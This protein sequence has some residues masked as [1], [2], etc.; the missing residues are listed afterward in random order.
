MTPEQTSRLSRR[1]I[2]LPADKRR[3]FLEQ[4][5][6]SGLDLS[7][8][9]I[10]PDIAPAGRSAASHAQRR[11]WFLWKLEPDSAAYHI[12]GAA[13]LRGQ[14]DVTALAQAFDRLLARHEGLRTTFVQDDDRVLQQVAAVASLSIA[15]SD[16]GDLDAQAREAAIE[17]LSI[18]EASAPFDLEHGPLLRVHL[19]RLAPDDHL[20][21]LTIHHIVF[22]G[23][24]MP[25]LL[26]ELIGLYDALSLGRAPQPK[27]SGVRYADYAAWQNAWL[28]AGEGE[29]QL[30]YWSDKLG[31]SEQELALPADRP[32]PDQPSH[33]GAAIAFSLDAATTARLKAL[34]VASRTTIYTV[35]AAAFALFLY[36]LTGRP[37][38]HIGMPAAGR[39]R[40]ELQR[41]IGLFVNMQVLR[42]P[43][44]PDFS[45]RRCVAE[46]HET[47]M[48]AQAHQDLPFD[49]LV[50][51][52]RAERTVTH[53]P[54][55]QVSY[56]HEPALSGR[57]STGALDWQFVEPDSRACRFDL[58][59]TTTEGVDGALHGS[60]R[61]A[62]DLFDA[63]TIEAW[64][65]A[66]RDL[67]TLVADAPDRSV[68][69]IDLLSTSERSRLLGLA[70][71]PDARGFSET[72]LAQIEAR[73]KQA[74]SAAAVILGD[75]VVSYGELNARANR[76]ARRLRAHGIGPDRLVGLALER[77]AEMIVAL[78]AV[79]KAGGAYLPL[80]PDYPVDRLGHMLRDSG[81]TLVLMHG[82]LADRLAPVLAEA[83][84][85][86]WSIDDEPSS[87]GIDNRNL[88]LPI[89][90]E[91]LAYVIYTSGSTGLPKGVAVAHGPLAMH[92][93][94]I[95][96]LYGMTASDRELQF[97]SINFDIAHERWLVPLT[98]GGAL[99]LTRGRDLPIDDLIAEVE[100]R[101]V[102]VLFLPPA[103][104]NQ[105]SGTLQRRGHQ[106]KL[107]ACIVG[108]EA[109]SDSGIAALRAVTDIDLLVNAYGPTETVIAPMA[110]PVDDAML[111]PGAYA[112]I[113]RPVGARSAY[114]LDNDL[115]L[116]PA[117]VTGE[118][119]IGGEGLARGYWGRAGLTAERF[120][121]D[122]FGNPGERL[123]RTGDLARWRADGLVEYVGRSDHQVKIRGFRI[124]LGEIEARLLLQAGVRAA[125]VVARDTGT[126][127]QLVGYVSGDAGLDGAQLRAT[128][129]ALLPDYMVPARI[130]VLDQLPLT[131]NGKVDRKALPEPEAIAAATDHVAPRNPVEAKLAAIWAE[132]LGQQAVSV[133]D[134]FFE[135][136]GDSIVSLQMVSRARQVGL[137]IEPRDVFRHQTLEA[138]A[139]IARTDESVH[140]GPVA[141]Q[142]PVE[143]SHPLLPIQLRFFG[144]DAG[145]RHHWNQAVLLEPRTRLDWAMLGRALEAVVDHHDALRLRFTETNGA[146]SAEY[147]AAPAVSELL[148]LRERITD[149]TEVTAVASLAQASLSLSGP[150]L[151]AVG[152]DLVDGSQRLLVVI[153]HLVIDGVSWRVL[154]EDVAAA[155]GQLASGATA[156][157]LPPKSQSFASW[158]ARL[159]TFAT[160]EELAAELPYW[161]ERRSNIQLSCDGDHDGVDR[162]ADADE[163][164]LVI[165]AALTSRLLK[166]TPSAYR[167]QVNDLLLAA[168]ARS[169]RQ[170]A[171][172]DELPIELEGHGREDVF[173]GAEIARTVGWFTTAFPVKLSG[174]ALDD[175]ELI[176]TVKEELRSIPGRGLGY[177]VLRYLGSDEQRAA[178]AAIDDPRIV[179]N[180]LGQLDAGVGEGS[181]F[182]MARE[183]AGPM[184]SASAPLGRWL[185]INGQVR[186]GQLRLSF[187]YGR[188]RYRRA[189][190]ERLAEAYAT[191]LRQLVDHCTGGVA[192][193]TPSDVAL[194]EL[195]QSELDALQLD[196]RNVEDIYP[197]SPMQQG[198]L[199]H[200]L[201]DA[202]SGVYVNQVA[203]E[204][205]GLDPA[206][207]R[208][209]WQAVSA[210]HAVLRT[211]FV[212]QGLS[213]AAQQV[214]YRQV[215]VPFA[216]EDWRE[217]A[218]GL[219]RA[220]LDATLANASQ[221]ERALGFD[222]S[223]PPMQR[224]RM[225]RLT[226]DSHWLIWTHHHILLDG[227][228]SARLIAEVLQHEGGGALPA[229][230]GHYRDY[231]GWLRQRDPDASA[232]FWRHSLARLD[233]PSFLAD[234]LGAPAGDQNTGHGSLPLSL[235]AE[236]TDRLQSFARRERV[237]LNTLVQGA[238][239]Q[240][241]RRYTGQNTISF[242]ATVSG[243]PADLAGSEEMIGLFIN[244]LP[245]VDDANP[246]TR[247]GDWLR[248]L[249]EQNLAL[250]EHGWTP[251]YEI[252][253]LA[254]R[255]GRPLF[256]SILV[257]EN[258]PVDQALR[259]KSQRVSVGDSKIVETS[260]YPLFVM[261]ALGDRLR[262]VFNYQLQHFDKTQIERLQSALIRLLDQLSRDAE[263]PLGVIA[264]QDSSD[265]TLLSAANAT[266]EF[267]PHA[268]LVAQIE[269]QAALHLDAVALV[270]GDDRIS[271]GELNARAN[272]LARRLQAHGIGPDR[273]VGLALGRNPSMMVA[274]L[275]VLKAG[276][277][278][279]PLDPDYPAERLA[280]M[281]R[282]SGATL[283]LTQRSLADLMAP[284]LAGAEVEAWML[285]EQ[286]SSEIDSGNLSLPIHPESLAYVIYT[287]GSTGL[288]KGVMVRHDAV[289]NFVATM[290]GQPGIDARD[291]VLG[292]TSLSFD[293]AVLELWLPL[294]VGARIVLVDRATAHDPARLK[295]I[296]ADEA[297]TVIQATPSTWRMLTDHE[298]TSLPST[299]RV[300][301]GGEALAPD[302]AR[303][304][305]AQAGEVWNVY[306]PTETTVWS[307]RHLLDPRDDR[308]RLGGPIGNTTLHI[309]DGDLNAAP[310]G[311]AGELYIGGEGLARGYWRRG[312]LTA[313]RFI[314]DPFATKPGERLYRTGDL[315]RWCADGVMEYVGR[316]DHQVKIRGFRI[317]LGEIETR[318]RAQP[319]VRDAVVIARE[320]GAGRQLVGY[321]VGED[322]LDPTSLR[323]AL[324]AQL[325][326]YMV[327]SR[328]VI[329]DR[330]PLTPNGKVDR[331]ALPAPD[332]LSAATERVAPRNP[333][334]VKLAAIWAD[335]LKQPDVGVTDNF[336]E[337]GGDSLVAVQVVDRIK[338]EFGCELPLRRLFEMTSVETMAAELIVLQ[339]DSLIEQ[340][341]GDIAAMFD[342]L[343]EVEFSDD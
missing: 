16:L 212:W 155:Y 137:I 96:R 214:V 31:G 323:A 153:H 321:V 211:G 105:L 208:V 23:W 33:R 146:W 255:P 271:Y 223:H 112:P 165:D 67:L 57:R 103:Y 143:G 65:E 236:L 161:Q 87:E 291:G 157:A 270:F 113:G 295:A 266:T 116:V 267:R 18:A 135:L 93:A 47:V 124:E 141:E 282:D 192:G 222:L 99:V 184:R 115:N 185:S 217:R 247:V 166:D 257:F 75:D 253:R 15:E 233:E 183:S 63:S 263:Q 219:D 318:L 297:V 22:D 121:P 248:G 34:G 337:L 19:I 326:D 181:P 198:L 191:A 324:A 11:M 245:V 227:W 40:S 138:L 261:V 44:M 320:A 232:T 17:P 301:C 265:R 5:R 81:A 317:E 73:A 70:T 288:P 252:Q 272:R 158:G 128:L 186:D 216:E 302:L 12:S 188:K 107:R 306:G 21:R 207:L 197:L 132:L 283:V 311:V 290:A 190:I 260:N 36:R 101:A 150:L 48:G 4:A 180:Y 42:T 125:V 68:G 286:Q 296:A 309:L 196:W 164:S 134:N 258:Y 69:T 325:P 225:I 304:L 98:T 298:G 187:G 106:L 200:A 83:G 235:D 289:T 278:Y 91:S 72:V 171:G 154:L 287:S 133:T 182:A 251:L 64:S 332:A 14:L 300:L 277:A 178:L 111:T 199:F 80:D 7:L 256:D 43:L 167:T 52:L 213:G 76:L 35:V 46:M 316:A 305:V 29:R 293:I 224:V 234:A 341:A 327:P 74:P 163:V 203:V 330:L 226:D 269:A 215:E 152:M 151:R 9:P 53:N 94:A 279:L 92:C 205:R 123:Y 140:E 292:L 66:F 86:A 343:K 58:E 169:L 56:S 89:I 10:P 88:D 130:M 85:T 310:V 342:M 6:A 50:R 244:T 312:A 41:V 120:I 79:L 340:R 104:A 336:F 28:E 20:L 313:E 45:F 168:L 268:S 243:R 162:V 26:D 242:G 314:P 329:L 39:G 139:L 170:W 221:A 175:A 176:K 84:V 209:A 61:Y 259:D 201:R 229:V 262:L 131:P 25:L 246:Q 27:D 30:A 13:R 173:A 102:S 114:I 334:E 276:G 55:F 299:C 241:L 335:L 160:T 54:L 119:Y 239:A 250:R 144:E 339:P 202:E 8:L 136:G 308:P 59:L 129:S 231:I 37:D 218:V 71:N 82:A 315:A 275:A 156:V 193:V 3:S 280:H 110:W 228:S 274:L 273:L 333:T 100:A 264:A 307:A 159:Q 90:S 194:S 145:E 303:R 230:Q 319:G 77:G 237:T 126:G 24:S 32:P 148:W 109:W 195:T 122:P 204:V 189:T 238:W 78:L 97:A 118:L 147:R 254:G 179:F 2:E 38:P 206:R 95:A 249:Q 177:G 142:G 294:A 285:D 322:D 328:T 60:L 51:A 49:W 284:V 210:R 172:L 281:L 174:G 240:L 338:R 117:G 220:A 62:I 1:F 149:A 127:R 331:K 108:G